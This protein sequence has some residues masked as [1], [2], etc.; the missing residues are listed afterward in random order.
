MKLWHLTLL[1]LA[2]IGLIAPHTSADVIASDSF[3]TGTGG[4]TVGST[5]TLSGQGPTVSGFTGTWGLSTS[6]GAASSVNTRLNATGLSF[7]DHSAGGAVESYRNGTGGGGRFLNHRA[8]SGSPQIEDGEN[9]YFSG[10]V[11]FVEGNS[12]GIGMRFDLRQHF[13]VGF[14]DE[15]RAG[16]W[17]VSSGGSDGGAFTF[18]ETTDTIFAAETTYL[19]VGQLAA[20]ASGNS[21][22]DETITLVG[23]YEFGDPIVEQNLLT[24]DFDVYFSEDDVPGNFGGQTLARASIIT[25]KSTGDVVATADE[26]RYGTEFIDVAPAFVIPEPATAGLLGLLSLALLRRSRRSS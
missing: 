5:T 24:A 15:G 22:N 8:F 16:V 10:L 3:I 11:S 12:V 18:I 1:L 25:S 23:V 9:L 7:G 21:L 26:L 13:G 2:T 6:D 20:E 14:N 17:Q 4:Y 19:I